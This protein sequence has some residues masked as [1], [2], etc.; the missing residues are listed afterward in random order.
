MNR[1]NLNAQ[2]KD[3]LAVLIRFDRFMTTAEIANEAGVSWNTAL[4]HLKYFY[5]KGWVERKGKTA[6][7]W[8]VIIADD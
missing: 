3:I 6:L 8:K 5:T 1:E 7:Y 2:A 4:N